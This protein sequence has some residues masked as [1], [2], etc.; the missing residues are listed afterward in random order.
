MNNKAK[1]L[2]YLSKDYSNYN[3]WVTKA[4]NNLEQSED[5]KPSK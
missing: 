5:K 2:L 1:E 4:N 3:N